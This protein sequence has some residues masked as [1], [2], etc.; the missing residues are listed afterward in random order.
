MKKELPFFYVG[1]SYGGNQDWCL[2]HIMQ[3]GG[4]G[5]I[6][7]LDSSIYF[8]LRRNYKNLYDGDLKKLDKEHYIQQA[9]RMKPYLHPRWTGIDKLYLFTEGYGQYLADHHEHGI[10][11]EE[12]D[13]DNDLHDAK[14]VV[15]RQIDAGMPIPCLILNHRNPEMEDYVWHWFLLIGYEADDADPLGPDFK[16][17]TVTYSEGRWIS[18]EDLWNTGYPVKGGLI[19]FHETK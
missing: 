9:E 1:D 5:A 8:A 2:D 18:F 16:V 3:L 14:E 6:T 12:Y 4:C 19:L 7:A 13:G 11:M 17:E 15:M 10:A